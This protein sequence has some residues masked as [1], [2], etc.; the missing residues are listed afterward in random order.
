M[1]ITCQLF[2]FCLNDYYFVYILCSKNMVSEQSCMVVPIS[3][4]CSESNKSITYLKKK[5]KKKT[6]AKT[7]T[8]PFKFRKSSGPPHYNSHAVVA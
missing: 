6:A 5:K 2:Y 1:I 7:T 4:S 3:P 8:L